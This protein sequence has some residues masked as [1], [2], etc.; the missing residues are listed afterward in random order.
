MM[1]QRT[2]AEQ[3]QPVYELFVKRY[4]S[5]QVAAKENPDRIRYLLNS[6]GLKWR[7]EKILEV[8]GVLAKD[9]LVPRNRNELIKLPGVGSYVANAFL[10]LFANT[11]APITDRN[12]VRI[13]GRIFGFE[14][15][16]ETHRKKW[17]IDLAEE[18]TPEMNFRLFNYA[19]LD[20]SR[21]ICKVKPD[22]NNCPLRPHC[23]YFCALKSVRAV[24]NERG[25]VPVHSFCGFELDSG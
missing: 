6:L 12:A 7:T 5:V 10:S 17:F 21:T 14:A 19:V 18:M 9:G 8:I 20:L 23:S 15:G 13:W 22:C 16:S 25:G 1:L 4:P 24:S 2:R 11:R 3:V